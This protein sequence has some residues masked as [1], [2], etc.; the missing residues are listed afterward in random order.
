MLRVTVCEN[1]CAFL[2]R[3][4]RED[5]R[6][7]LRLYLERRN[8]QIAAAPK[9]ASA[10]VFGSG[11]HAK[12]ITPKAPGPPIALASYVPGAQVELPDTMLTG[13]MLPDPQVNICE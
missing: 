6:K 5:S 2:R 8:A 3:C 12:S 11:I 4:R 1:K 10:S 13:V 7:I 9:A